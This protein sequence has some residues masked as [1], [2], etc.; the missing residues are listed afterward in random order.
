MNNNVGN[1]LN[2][3]A[4]S[5]LVLAKKKW[6]YRSTFYFVVSLISGFLPSL[7][8]CLLYCDYSVY[9]A[10]LLYW[11]G[12]LA[13]IISGIYAII[14]HLSNKE[15][16]NTQRIAKLASFVVIAFLLIRFNVNLSGDFY[17]YNSACNQGRVFIKTIGD[18]LIKHATDNN[19]CLLPQEKWSDILLRWDKNISPY[20]FSVA[21]GC[22][23]NFAF[24]N[25]IA[26]ININNL[27]DNMVVVFEA[28]GNFNLSGGKELVFEKR[29]KDRLFLREK[30]VFIYIYF[31]DGTVAKYRMSD[32]AISIYDFRDDLFHGYT[33][34]SPYIPLQWC[35]RE[36][37]MG[38]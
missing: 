33:N 32:N 10:M 19:S 2:S 22:E 12:G 14:C 13:F 30:D 17:T 21:G 15:M 26:G 1:K 27:P 18:S 38:N 29:A 35:R 7:A 37:K 36:L 28:D 8:I 20:L 34:A 9:F 4:K 23:S 24:N 16:N 5:S 3:Q 11:A 31:R 6:L 25:N